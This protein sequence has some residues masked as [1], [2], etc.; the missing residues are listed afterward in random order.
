MVI[1][2]TPAAI[3]FACKSA[4][5]APP[6]VGTGGSGGSGADLV[7]SMD[8][9]RSPQDVES[10][11]VGWERYRQT[12]IP[13]KGVVKVKSGVAHLDG[14]PITGKIR[15]HPSGTWVGRVNNAE[16]RVLFGTTQ[17]EVARNAAR[18]IEGSI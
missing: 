12:L 6:P 17:T 14:K 1:A 4:A 9:Y 18:V 5:C 11:R 15:K 10:A 3:E 16:R 2:R 8:H 13:I 7:R